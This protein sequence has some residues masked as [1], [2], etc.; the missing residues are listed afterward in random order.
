M[1][2]TG[3]TGQIPVWLAGTLVGTAV[4]KSVP[5]CCALHGA[6]AKRLCIHAY[7]WANGLDEVTS[8]RTLMII[9][10][11]WLHG[12]GS[13]RLCKDAYPGGAAA[14]PASL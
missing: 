8:P 4:I 14:L 13:E 7:M 5:R 12:A 9:N 1:Y 10:W 3:T 2:N 11:I 6:G